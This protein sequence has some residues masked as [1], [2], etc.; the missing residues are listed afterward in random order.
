MA[1]TQAE[2]E[3]ILTLAKLKMSGEDAVG[4]VCFL[5]QVGKAE[6]ML[7]WLKSREQNPP[8]DREVMDQLAILLH[9]DDEK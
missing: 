8:T 6:K 1:L 9:E 7:D 4:V 3:V 5:H 2:E